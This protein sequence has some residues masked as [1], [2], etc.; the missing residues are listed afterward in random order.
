MTFIT[1]IVSTNVHQTQ[2]SAIKDMA[3]RSARIEG[4]VSLTWGLPSFRTPEYIRQGIKQV[5]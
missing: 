3:M 1:D 4:A 5:L 2:I